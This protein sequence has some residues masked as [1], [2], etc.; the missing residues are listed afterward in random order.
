MT[1]ELQCNTPERKHLTT[2][3]EVLLSYKDDL[4]PAQQHASEYSLETEAS[5]L[6]KA[7]GIIKQDILK[8]KLILLAL[9]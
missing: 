9:L 1:V 6:C 3:K 8:K 4:V 7:A 2:K 5:Y